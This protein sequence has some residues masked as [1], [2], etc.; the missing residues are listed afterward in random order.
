MLFILSGLYELPPQLH[1]QLFKFISMKGNKRSLFSVLTMQELIDKLSS[2][3]HLSLHTKLV[4]AINKK[5]WQ[6]MK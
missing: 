5:D 3:H 2:K 4:I 6:G 1:N